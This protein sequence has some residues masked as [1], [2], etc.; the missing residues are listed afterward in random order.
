MNLIVFFRMDC[1]MCGCVIP[2]S[3][4]FFRVLNLLSCDMVVDS[5]K[6]FNCDDVCAVCMASKHVEQA[7]IQNCLLHQLDAFEYIEVL[8]KLVQC[9]P[10]F[11]F[12]GA[13][14][15]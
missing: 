7:T 14:L 15:T 5:C 2:N 9:F 10:I 6:R 11:F 13:L 8:L 1:L 12:Y 4:G 3:A